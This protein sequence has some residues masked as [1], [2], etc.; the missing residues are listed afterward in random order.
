MCTHI[1]Y[2]PFIEWHN[3]NYCTIR[4]LKGRATEQCSYLIS[5]QVQ[6][7]LNRCSFPNC[8]TLLIL[9]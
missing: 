5:L 2:N 1:L 8:F 4:L 3:T 7:E 9:M 6:K